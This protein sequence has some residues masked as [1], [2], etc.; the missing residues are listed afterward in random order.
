MLADSELGLVVQSVGRKDAGNPVEWCLVE[1]RLYSH[2]LDPQPGREPRMGRRH[3][4]RRTQYPSDS[5]VALASACALGRPRNLLIFINPVSGTRKCLKLW[6][7]SVQPMLER[8]EV[9]FTVVE[10][11]RQVSKNAA[12]CGSVQFTIFETM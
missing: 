4:I 7:L 10:T 12:S 5:V 8:A 1:H 3:S 6:E 9:K 2:S 11:M